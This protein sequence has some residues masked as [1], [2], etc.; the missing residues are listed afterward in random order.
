M[1]GRDVAVVI[2]ALVLVILLVSLLGGLMM[3]WGMM[4][5]GMMGWGAL[6]FN[7]LGWILM[8]VFW[9]LIIGGVA[10]LALWFLREATPAAAGPSA[11]ARSLDILKERFARGEISREQYEEMR[12]VLE[13]R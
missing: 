10:L 9:V 1:R 11:P 6:G 2:G 12:R 13:G 7:P 5:P 3:G 4:G 8:L